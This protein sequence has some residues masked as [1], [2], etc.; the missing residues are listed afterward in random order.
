MLDVTAVGGPD[1]LELR[2]DDVLLLATKTQDSADLLEAWGEAA[3]GTRTAAETLPV[4]C[5]QN[6]VSNERLAAERFARV[7]GACVWQRRHGTGHR[8]RPG[9]G[10]DRGTVR[11]DVMRWKHGKLLGNLGNVFDALFA[12][13]ES[14]VQPRAPQPGRS[15]R[16]PCPRPV[17]RLHRWG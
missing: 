3:V 10:P 7:Y 5:L 16:T 13:D 12:D 4:A 14:W 1:E 2:G 6:G 11:E 8:G 9:G 15:G 17:D